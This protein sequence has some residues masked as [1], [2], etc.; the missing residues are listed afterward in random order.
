MWCQGGLSPN[1]L[2]GGRIFSTFSRKA[3]TSAT[4]VA[5]QVEGGVA[6]FGL[7]VTI[8][9]RLDEELSDRHVAIECYGVMVRS[10]CEQ[11]ELDVKAAGCRSSRA[12]ELALWGREAQ[13][14]RRGWQHVTACLAGIVVTDRP[15]AVLRS[16]LSTS[17][18][19]VAASSSLVVQV[20]VG[21]REVAVA[22][23]QRWTASANRSTVCNS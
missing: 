12:S 20:A 7:S 5:C 6:R 3:T 1:K 19:A 4:V 2:D 11:E 16:T 21:H 22:A 13:A 23:A 18:S 17:P 8:A 15:L 14:D 9:R 10:S